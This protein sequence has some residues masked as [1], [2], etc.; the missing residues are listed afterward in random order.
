MAKEIKIPQIAEGVESATVTEVLVKEGDSI[1][2]DQSI[3]A[4]ESDKASVEIPSPQ[5]GTVK[6]ISVSEGDEV[7][8]G[9]VILEL[10]EGDAEEDPEEDKEE[11]SEKDNESEKDEDSEKEDSEK[12]NS[13]EEEK[14]DKS[15]KDKKSTSEEEDSGSSEEK[16]KASEN[17]EEDAAD[18][19]G[20]DSETK[21][22]KKDQDNDSED[23]KD[24]KGKKSKKDQEDDSED[25]EKDD[26]KDSEKEK[27]SRT[28]D[29]A[30]APGVR[31]FARELGVDISEV[32]GSGEAGRISKEDVKAHNKGSNSQQ[33]KTSNDLSLPDFSKWGE[34]ERKAISGIRKATAKN[35]SAAWST[36]PH[37]FQF[38]EA[39]ISDIEE[40]MEKLQEKADG[41]LTITAILAKISASALRQ[42]P[43]FNA[44]IDM[45]NEEM[46]LKKYVNIG[47]A[48]DTEKGLLVPVV[49]NADQKTII[50]ISTEI[51]ELAE[52]ARNVKLSAEEMKGGNF[53]ISNLGGIGGTNFTPIVYH[54]Q[55]AI[56][57]VSRAKK[58]PV[59]KDDDTFEARDILPLSL[60]YDHRIID[61]AE[62]VRFLHWI[63]RA[64]ED[65]YEALLGA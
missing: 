3:I 2:K 11:E 23:K 51:T 12:E 35:T 37:V 9:D 31:R 28:E 1:E 56:L 22:N 38:D 13:E 55:V 27:T 41:N 44:S 42:F 20:E 18:E 59:Y 36:I 7:E 50:E 58:Q 14:E 19:D 48:V 53:T 8:V 26:S 5:A 65:P 24:S 62:G 39:D 54:P 25:S 52:K 17:K 60:S 43:K 15:K 57:G 46:I 4:V 64:L 45:E 47:I 30:A 40:R 33:G 29:V 61:G 21:K 16:E 63:S 6:S 34:T 49:R 10:E 32:K